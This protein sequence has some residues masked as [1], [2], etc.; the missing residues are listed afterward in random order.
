[1]IHLVWQILLCWWM[2]SNTLNVKNYGAVGNGITDDTNAIQT[3]LTAANS[4]NKNLYFPSGIYLCNT[5]NTNGHILEFNAGNTSNV[6]I[7]GNPGHSI[8]KTT[9][10]SASVLLYVYAFAKSTGLTITG[11]NFL[12]THGKITGITGAIFETGTS[13]QL[14]DTTYLTQCQFNGFSV[15]VGGQGIVGWWISNNSFGAPNGHDNAEQNSDPA[16]FVWFYDNANG[17]CRHVYVQNNNVN[18]YT[19]ALPLNCPRPMDGFVYGFAYDLNIGP[20]NVMANLSEEY[21]MILPPTTN[22]STT[23]YVTISGNYLECLLPPGC[24]DDNG[25]LHKYNYGIR[26][27]ASHVKIT[28]NTIDNY[29]WGIMMRGIDYPSNSFTDYTINNNILN[30]PIDTS[31]NIKQGSIFI[32]GYSLSPVTN[33]N[34]SSNTIY[35][36][37][38]TSYQ[39]LNCTSPVVSGMNEYPVKR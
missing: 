15:T 34:V 3:A 21:I 24:I 23:D 11:I 7:Y 25:S 4:Q 26:A 32:D 1:M 37:D 14:L 17:Y 38:S 5:I 20:G 36:V 22:P 19:G 16:V 18:G 31:T 13:G 29:V 27:D 10:N 39:I 35:G 9:N 33:V 8:I 30:A 2:S 28:N 12:N 6:Y